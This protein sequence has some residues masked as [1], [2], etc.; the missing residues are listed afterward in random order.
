MGLDQPVPIEDKYLEMATKIV[1]SAV[2]SQQA[3]SYA[4]SSPDV[5]ATLVRT[6]CLELITLRR[7]QY[8]LPPKR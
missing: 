2:S 3:G 5:A 4:M 8:E 1:A 7:G 6:I